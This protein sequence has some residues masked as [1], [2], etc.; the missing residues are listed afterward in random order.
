MPHAE[1]LDSAFCCLTWDTIADIIRHTIFIVV[2]LGV[3]HY[4]KKKVI[5]KVFRKIT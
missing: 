3:F 1:S 2:L 4:N 5:L